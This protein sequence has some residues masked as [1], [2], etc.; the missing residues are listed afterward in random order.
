M[1]EPSAKLDLFLAAA[2]IEAKRPSVSVGLASGMIPPQLR[3]LMRR[4]EEER[5]GEQDD[6]SAGEQGR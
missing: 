6:R 1:P 5:S 2:E 3:E 4:A